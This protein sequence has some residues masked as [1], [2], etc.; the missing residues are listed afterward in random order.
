MSYF[1]S[2]GLDPQNMKAINNYAE[3]TPHH[4]SYTLDGAPFKITNRPVSLA[5]VL[6]SANLFL[7]G[8]PS[9]AGSC[10][11]TMFHDDGTN[12]A[13]PLKY[14][15][16]RCDSERGLPALKS[17]LAQHICS[18]KEDHGDKAKPSPIVLLKSK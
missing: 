11:A 8:C 1:A 15:A 10:T 12:P 13:Q 7:L 2:N 14:E 18:F 6:L 4:I 16:W 9:V 17:F 5:N 3:Y